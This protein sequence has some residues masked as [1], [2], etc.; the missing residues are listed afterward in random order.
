MYV[1]VCM[2]GVLPRSPQGVTC[3]TQ[4]HLL[5]SF[6]VC[7]RERGLGGVLRVGFSLTL[8]PGIPASI[9]NHRLFHSTAAC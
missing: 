3:G 6:T 8:P 5:L 2:G 9:H 7:G 1:Y 4:G